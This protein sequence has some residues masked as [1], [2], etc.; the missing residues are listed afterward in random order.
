[1]E[2]LRATSLARLRT[3]TLMVAGR[4]AFWREI[5]HPATFD[6]CN[7]IGQEQASAGL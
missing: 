2:N 5:C 4:M 6:F 3:Q 1:M 7:N